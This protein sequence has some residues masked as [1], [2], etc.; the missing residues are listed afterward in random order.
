MSFQTAA[1]S[2]PHRCSNYWK[3]FSRLQQT[4]SSRKGWNTCLLCCSK[5]FRSWRLSWASCF[6]IA[7]DFLDLIPLKQMSEEVPQRMSTDSAHASVLQ[8]PGTVVSKHRLSPEVCTWPRKWHWKMKEIDRKFPFVPCFM[9]GWNEYLRW[10]WVKLCF[11]VWSQT[12]VSSRND[13]G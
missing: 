2:L 5:M 1:C 9:M 8:S 6:F 4:E 3:I 13:L 10:S 12:T 7:A 11:A